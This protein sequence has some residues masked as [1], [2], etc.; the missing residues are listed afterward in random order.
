MSLTVMLRR[1]Q[2][3]KWRVLLDDQTSGACY[4]CLV[5]WS[6]GWD[7]ACGV[8]GLGGALALA[9]GVLRGLG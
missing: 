4:L 3:H 2:S 1:A 5:S 9:L 6:L 7:F 8:D